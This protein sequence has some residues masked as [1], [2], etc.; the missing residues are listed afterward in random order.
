MRA[1]QLKDFLNY[2]FLS[3]VKY[4]PGGQRAAFVV[5]NCNEEDNC[6]ESRLWLWD[7]QLRQLTDLGKEKTFLWEDETHIL[8][9]AVRSAKEKKRAEA[10]EQFTSWYRLD[11]TGG[12][13]V[14]AFTLPF[15]ASR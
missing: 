8:F 5:S 12:E 4:A 15:A 10:K 9:P 7:G 13:A 1:L 3:N 2:K 6:Y 14:H 11:V